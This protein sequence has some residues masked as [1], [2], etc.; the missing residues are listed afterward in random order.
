MRV[1][2]PA[3]I[4]ALVVAAS[5]GGEPKSTPTPAAAQ[6][7]DLG[8]IK[9]YLLE[10]TERLKAD[11][12]QL[13][14]DAEAYYELAE[15]AGFDYEALLKDKRPE[16]AAA[17]KKLQDDHIE[18]N[19]SYEEME[20]VVAGVPELADFDV[21]LDAGGDKSDPENAVPF[22]LETPAGRKFEQPGNFFALIE[23]SAFG[24][25]E[26]FTANGVKADLDG[27]GDVTF[28]EALPD[29]DFF[30]AA[31]REMAS[32]AS[33]L[34]AAARKWEPTLQDAF[35]AVVVMTPTMSEYF[36]AWK[37]SRFVAGGDAEEKGFVATSRLADIRDILG[38][39]VLIYANIRP[40][41]A[42]TDAAQAEQTEKSLEDLHA[43]ATRLYDEEQDGKKFT[44]SDADT[45]GTE[46][47][48]NAEAIAGQVSQ[49]AGT[50]GITLED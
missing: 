29:A 47:Q 43:F 15:S 42:K 27:D 4:A 5:G 1:L 24:T 18:A 9:A 22:S 33:A 35:T 31:A 6:A 38:G 2:F 10:H 41:V 3:A 36:G 17:V 44:A 26:R 8:A 11:T 19:P 23:T 40:S 32:N 21:I 49:A 20:G 16:V 48:R 25:E 50:L 46:A 14:T 28:P 12:A 45:L 30:V 37:N 7:A 13:Q 39:I 34:D